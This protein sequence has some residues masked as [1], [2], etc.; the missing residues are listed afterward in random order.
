MFSAPPFLQG[1]R[2]SSFLI[3]DI[4]GAQDALAAAADRYS[5]FEQTLATPGYQ[6]AS[7]AQQANPYPATK[8]LGYYSTA[9]G[10]QDLKRGYSIENILDTNTSKDNGIAIPIP[11]PVYIRTRSPLGSEHFGKPKR[12]RR[13][14]TVFTDLQLMAL[15]KRFET[16]KYLS[17]PDRIEVAEGLGLTQLQV[18]TW[19]QNRRMKWKKQVLQ[20][21]NTESPTKPK[22]RPRKETF[23]VSSTCSADTTCDDVITADEVNYESR[24]K[25]HSE[26]R[27]SVNNSGTMNIRIPPGNEVPVGNPAPHSCC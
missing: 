15:E 1:P 2:S 24:V 20:C 22:G 25:Y 8:E 13:S 10:Y 16:Q 12:C 18:K 3:R 9:F 21:G 4:L 14:R 19:Y 17:T 23:S 27:Q 7:V 6:P 5:T 11:L 26:D